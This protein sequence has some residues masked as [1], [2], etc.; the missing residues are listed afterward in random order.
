[1]LG[2]RNARPAIRR[3]AFVCLALAASDC[4]GGSS[5]DGASGQLGVR[6]RWEQPS[7]HRASLAGARP[8]PQ[9][10]FGAAIPAAVNA[11]RI[12]VAPAGGEPCCMAVS[13]GSTAFANRRVILA[14]LAG[15]E[16]DVTISGYPETFAPAD[17]IGARCP[18]IPATDAEACVA[19]ARTLPSFASD[20]VPVTVVPGERAST[21]DVLIPSVPFL[22]DRT[23]AEGATVVRARVPVRFAVVSAAANVVATSIAVRA[24]AAGSPP[25]VFASSMT[26]SPCDERSAGGTVRC[27]SGADL[28][29][30][31]FLVDAETDALPAGPARVTIEASDNATPP[32]MLAFSYDIMVAPGATTTTT[33]TSTTTPSASTTTLGATTTTTLP[34]ATTTTTLAPGT[35]TTTAAPTTTSSTTSTTVPTTTTTITTTTSTTLPAGTDRCDVIFG[36]TAPV[37]V[38]ALV[39]QVDYLAT[40]GGFEGT[41]QQVQCFGLAGDS[42]NFND[43]DAGAVL[44][45]A[46]NSGNG[47][48]GPADVAVCSYVG[49]A[50]PGFEVEGFAIETLRAEDPQ[51]GPADTGAEVTGVTCGSN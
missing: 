42:H 19:G 14:G 32:R 4:G 16:I 44:S 37:L 11:V 6:A 9:R 51:G 49:P 10:S 36:F 30:A 2:G 43:D 28:D 38:G 40:E 48:P 35:T 22:V 41:G 50:P 29:V 12:V 8:V 24:E 31:G 23:P 3:L 21:G 7:A 25:R 33:S 26:L 1:M 15:G 34:A 46:M 45:I 18:T 47:V 39:F 13:R 5:G 20:P 27:T 17:G